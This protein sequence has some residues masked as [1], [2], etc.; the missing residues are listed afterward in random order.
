MRKTSRSWSGSRVSS[1][2]R[3][4]RRDLRRCSRS[5][6]ARPVR[7]SSQLWTAESGVN[8]L[9]SSAKPAT[10]AIVDSGIDASAPDVAGRVK[11]QVSFV[12]STYPNAA[13]DGRG[14]G[15]F[16]AGIAA[17]SAKGYAG[18]APNADIVSLD[19]MDDRGAGKTSD[20]IAAA[21]WI[22]QNKAAYNIRVANFSLHSGAVNHFWL[23]PLN[24][25]VEK[26]WHS[27][28]VVVAAAGN[29]GTA[30][31]ASGVRYAPGSDP[32]VITVG[33]SDIGG[34]ARPR[35]DDRAPWSAYGRTPDGFWKPEICAPGR[36]MVGPVPTG[37]TLAME[38]ADKMVASG[39]A[40]LSG[41][42]FAAPVIS[43]VAAQILGRNP[44]WTADQVKSALM[45]RAR[46]V[47]QA[48]VRLVRCRSGQRRSVGAGDD[49][50]AESE[51][52]AERVPGHDGRRD[53]RV[54]CGLLD[55]RVLERRLV[56]CGLVER[57]LLER[58]LLGCRLLERRLL[59][60]RLLERCL[61]ERR[62]VGGQ[63]RR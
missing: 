39:Y 52:G 26:L 28:V 21:E 60:G 43:G 38:K 36:Y 11:T 1:S 48:A 13:G 35:D 30:N 24:V 54:R 25:A 10:I 8:K 29:Y 16:V 7:V 32:F 27:G 40:E 50:H 62:L 61:L 33:A 59:D 2:P 3:T 56:G 58:R 23:D 46:P 6:Q 9:W 42:S 63:R 49:G 15:T 53:D 19:V 41:T 37:S 31:A 57:R 51:P 20:V 18:V 17:G 22:Y 5:R 12:T 44:S 34:T 14:H 55:G 45:R 4:L 47:P